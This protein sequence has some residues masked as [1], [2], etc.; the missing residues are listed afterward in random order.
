MKEGSD[1]TLVATGFMTHRAVELAERL[2]GHGLNVGVV[3]LF[4]LKP[5]D[6]E[7]LAKA[8]AG[9]PK[10]V[11]LE[12]NTLIGGLGSMVAETICDLGLDLRL[13]RIGL[14]DKPC[15]DYGDRDWILSGL[16]MDLEGLEK[17]VLDWVK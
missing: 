7:R 17:R 6:Q 9:A 5:L 15:Y 11:T 4:R 10:A 3:D 13:K 1:L 16:G 14:P 12:E 2:A 8:L